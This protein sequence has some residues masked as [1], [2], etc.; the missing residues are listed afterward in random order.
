MSQMS[1]VELVL[2]NR[3]SRVPG[4]ALRQVCTNF[5]IDP[6]LRQYAVTSR[7]SEDV[8]RTFVSALKGETIEVTKMNFVG[9]STLCDEFG[10][11]LKSPSYR[12]AQ[13]ETMIEELK[14]DMGRL[15]SEVIALRGIPRTTEQLSKAITQLRAD[16][17]MVKGWTGMP[18]SLIL[19]DL[20]A[21][22]ANSRIVSDFSEI[23]AEFRTKQFSVLWQG[24]RDGFSASEFHR[25]CDGHTNTLTMI[26]DTEGNIF[27][28]FTPVKWESVSEWKGDGSQKSFLFTLKNPHKVP[29]RRFALKAEKKHQAICCYFL[30]GPHFFDIAVCDQCNANTSSSTS[31]FGSSYTNDTGLNGKTFFT[32]SDDFQVKEIE[33]FEI[34]D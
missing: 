12:L 13:V 31:N 11:K 26:L 21:E 15:S 19:N 30:R 33:V 24:G 18:N 17:S 16:V 32:G 14:T 20:E 4:L 2:N 7:V 8:F 29:A 10:F 28:A 25:R 34:K 1:E 6:S 5:P 3:V 9:L 22:P 27:G 23:F